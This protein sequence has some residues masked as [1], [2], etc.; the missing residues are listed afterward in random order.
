L[1]ASG[2]RAA[3]RFCWVDL[4]AADAGKAQ[5]FYGALFGWQPVEQ[6]ANGGMFTR[7]QHAGEDVGSMYQLSRAQLGQGAASHWI[8]YVQVNDVE[9]ATWRAGALGGVVLVR[10]F[11]VAGIARIAVI[12]DAV[13]AAVGLWEPLPEGAARE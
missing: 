3:G 12:L 10:P 1:I 4:A 8:P 7:L 11:A 2:T 13:G 9:Q 5:A 6:W